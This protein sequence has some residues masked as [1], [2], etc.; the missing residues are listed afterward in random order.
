[1]KYSIVINVQHKYQRGRSLTTPIAKLI[2]ANAAA[3]DGN[4]EI[5]VVDHHLSKAFDIEDYANLLEKLC[6]YNNRDVCYT[7][8]NTFLW[9]GN[10]SLTGMASCLIFAI[11]HKCF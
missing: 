6:Y 9:I 2:L 4:R 5:V 10:D 3:F 1:M 8:V 11:L 7:L